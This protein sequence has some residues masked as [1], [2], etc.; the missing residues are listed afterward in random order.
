VNIDELFKKKFNSELDFSE[1]KGQESIKRAL[2]IAA[3]GRT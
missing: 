1:V 3:A 2:E